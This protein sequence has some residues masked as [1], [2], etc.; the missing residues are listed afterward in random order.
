MA[1]VNELGYVF[2]QAKIGPRPMTM[3]EFIEHQN[4]EREKARKYIRKLEKKLRKEKRKPTRKEFAR[5]VAHRS[6]PTRFVPQHYEMYLKDYEDEEQQSAMIAEESEEEEE[7]NSDPNL[8]ITYNSKDASN[9]ENRQKDDQ[10]MFRAGTTHENEMRSR[11]SDNP[12]VILD[13][14]D[15]LEEYKRREE[16]RIIKKKELSKSYGDI[17]NLVYILTKEIKERHRDDPNLIELVD[18][19][20]GQVQNLNNYIDF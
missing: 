10:Y 1:D 13:E 4:R 3:K 14:A 6:A 11:P 19:L 12:I 20:Q 5:L 16:N 15:E 2:S 8:S 17:L 18:N 7:E 9:Q